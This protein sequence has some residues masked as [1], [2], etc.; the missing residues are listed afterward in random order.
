MWLFQFLMFISWCG[1][2]YKIA[3]MHKYKN[4]IKENN[5]KVSRN[6]KTNLGKE[7]GEQEN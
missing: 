3:W 2:N 6:V 4:R 5:A 7:A 1:K